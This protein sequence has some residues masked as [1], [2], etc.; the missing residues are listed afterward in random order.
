MDVID[1]HVQIQMALLVNIA[2][3]LYSPVKEAFWAVTGHVTIIH[4]VHGMPC[5]C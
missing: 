3:V 4:V 1:V 2:T 5:L